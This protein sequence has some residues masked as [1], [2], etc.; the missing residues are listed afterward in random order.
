MQYEPHTKNTFSSAIRKELCDVSPTVRHCVLAEMSAMLEIKCDNITAA[1]RLKQLCLYAFNHE[2]YTDDIIKKATRFPAAVVHPCCKRAYIRGSFI[3]GGTCNDP[4][5]SYHLE[6]VL[7]QSITATHLTDTFRAFEL[8]PKQMQRKNNTVV[9]F[10][11]SDSIVQ[12]LTI[13]EANKAMLQFENVRVIKEI[14]N[15]VNRKVNFETAN[16]TKIVN[17]A[18]NQIDDI[19]L[20]NSTV[21]LEWLPEPLAQVARLR[22][23]YETAGLKEIGAMLNPP[24]SKSGVNH[25][26]RKISEKAQI[27]KER[28]KC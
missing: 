28:V 18:V 25:R 21:G 16:L 12:V 2:A 1:Q 26:L 22:L 10:K 14:G 3:A 6:F 15:H 13:M 5:N 17:A 7:P 19:N 20:I 11:E 27:L 8:S 24:I 23:M 9:Y 4:N